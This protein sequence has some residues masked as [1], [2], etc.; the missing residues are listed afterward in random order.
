MCLCDSHVKMLC[1]YEGSSINKLQNSVI[2][3]I[4]KYKKSEMYIL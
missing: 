3:L 1:M 4:L 2:L